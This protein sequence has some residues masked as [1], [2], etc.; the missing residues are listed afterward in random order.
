MCFVPTVSTIRCWRRTD[1]AKYIVCEVAP[2]Y[3]GIVRF[4][5]MKIL[6]LNFDHIDAV[7]QDVFMVEM[8]NGNKEER[9]GL[10]IIGSNLRTLFGGRL[11]VFKTYDELLK[12]LNSNA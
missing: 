4:E 5:D 6:A 12:E 7:H 8:G 9:L 10:E 1:M 2:V 3:E 11:V